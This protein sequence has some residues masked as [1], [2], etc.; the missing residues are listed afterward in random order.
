MLRILISLLLVLW[1]GA[2]MFFPAVAAIAFT[3]L[4][5]KHSAGLVVR[6]SLLTLNKEGL[7]AGTL[8]LVFLLLA[9]A[10]KAYGRTLIGPV[11]CTIAMLLLTAFLQRGIIPRMDADQVAVGGDVDT[12]TVTD[13]HRIEFNRL[14]AAS[15]EVEEGVL[16]AG[17][18]MVVFLARPPRP[19]PA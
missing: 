16:V 5:D 11:L 17:I 8:L 1:L 14:H 13:P 19:V 12:A 2:V 7:V 18:A 3:V 6:T 10:R 9:A 4:P 15:E